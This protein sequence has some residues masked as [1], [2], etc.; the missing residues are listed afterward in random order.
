MTELSEEDVV[1]WLRGR[2]DKAFVQAFYK[3]A[4]GRRLV[5][6]K[7]PEYESHLAVVHLTKNSDAPGDW[8]MEFIGLPRQSEEWPDDAPIMEQGEHCFQ[9]VVSVAKNF[10]CPLCGGEV[11]AT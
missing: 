5:P 9:T 10:V 2:T 3:A 8:E 7:N 4:A 6:L 1:A 11:S